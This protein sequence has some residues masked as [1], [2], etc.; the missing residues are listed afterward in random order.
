MLWHEKVTLFE[1]FFQCKKCSMNNSHVLNHF[2]FP[3]QHKKLTHFE[4]VFFLMP[5]DAAWKTHAFWTVYFFATCCSTKNSNILNH[6]NAKWRG[7]S[8]HKNSHMHFLNHFL[9]KIANCSTKKIKLA[10]FELFVF[11]QMVQHKN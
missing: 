2:F 6:F 4:T 11:S 8:M 3:M 10:L 7:T 9:G 1:P 5:N